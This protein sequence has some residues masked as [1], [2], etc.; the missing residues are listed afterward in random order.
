MT[1]TTLQD[2]TIIHTTPGW[3]GYQK[4]GQ[5]MLKTRWFRD[6]MKY[7]EVQGSKTT[8]TVTQNW[9]GTSAKLGTYSCEC[10]GFQF[11]KYCKHVNEI[12][13]AK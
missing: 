2:G 5:P 1:S 3:T 8:Y 10:K 12:K 11:R 13:G 6:D 4:S 9:N 7:W